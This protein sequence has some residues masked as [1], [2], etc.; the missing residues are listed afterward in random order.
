MS[1]ISNSAVHGTIYGI[2]SM[3]AVRA[4]NWGSRWVTFLPKA[5]L[6]REL[7]ADTFLL[8]AVYG[9]CNNIAY[10][11][12]SDIR[13]V[14]LTAIR[15]GNTGF[16]IALTESG[17]T[18]ATSAEK[19]LTKNI[20]EIATFVTSIAVT[21]IAA[22]RLA[23]YFGREITRQAAAEFAFKVALTSA[24]FHHITGISTSISTERS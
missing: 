1:I 15:A 20:V 24:L 23:I 17:R 4:A 2:L 3:A 6:T 9:I 14:Y 18:R 5:D 10:T 11:M 8:G 13:D 12:L 19:R 21:S 22:P 7:Y 16:P